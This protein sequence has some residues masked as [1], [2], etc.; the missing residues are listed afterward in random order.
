MDYKKFKGI[1]IKS[2]IKIMI[3]A[4]IILFLGGAIISRI[5]L[6]DQGSV[7]GL[8]I[9]GGIFSLLGLIVLIKILPATIQVITNKHPLLSAINLHQKNY[10]VWITRKQINT[11]AGH[12]GPTLGTSQNF[13]IYDNEGK[14]LE[15]TLGR[16]T[17]PNSI[18]E[19]LTSEF[20]IPYIGYSDETRDAVN[21]HFGRTEGWKK[22]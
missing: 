17:D 9:F 4:V 5:F 3:I 1:L 6:S 8:A 12:G 21:Q 22:L 11:T 7:I 19:Y 18:V 13:I 2:N 16:K 15:L 20:N 14:G 10:I